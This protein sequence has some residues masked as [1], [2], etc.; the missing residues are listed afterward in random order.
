MMTF[1][2]HPKQD[3]H[4][5]IVSLVNADPKIW[6]APNMLINYVFKQVIGYFID[7]ILKFSETVH[8]KEWGQRMAQRPEFYDF[9][10][11]LVANYLRALSFEN[12]SER[13]SLFGEHELAEAKHKRAK[14]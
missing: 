5:E 3:G 9:L 1:E 13:E 2:I 10:K 12:P 7:K 14:Q 4:V 6:F 11:T 8:L